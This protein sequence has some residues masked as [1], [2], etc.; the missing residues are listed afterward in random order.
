MTSFEGPPSLIHIMD[1]QARHVPKKTDHTVVEAFGKRWEIT[2]SR[3]A[4]WTA[5][6]PAAMTSQLPGRNRPESVNSARSNTSLLP[7]PLSSYSTARIYGLLQFYSIFQ[8]LLMCSSVYW[9]LVY[10][11]SQSI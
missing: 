5:S 6:V 4:Q 1:D 2:P 10:A 8:G 3:L 11:I 9:L 7:A